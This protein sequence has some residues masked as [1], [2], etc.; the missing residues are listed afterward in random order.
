[1]NLSGRRP[2]GSTVVAHQGRELNTHALGRSSVA[3]RPIA[4]ISTDGPAGRDV[5]PF[6]SYPPVC[7]EPPTIAV[8][9][10]SVR[11][12]SNA[13][14]VSW[15]NVQATGEFVGCRRRAAARRRARCSAR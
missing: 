5:A 12:A 6:R 14:K 3:P 10:G 15:L 8:T 11:E 2:D 4:M 9:I 13:P 7:G 1:M